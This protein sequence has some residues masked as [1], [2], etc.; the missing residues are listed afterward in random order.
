VASIKGGF[1]PPGLVVLGEDMGEVAAMETG[2]HVQA[3]CQC[4]FVFEIQMKGIA[5][6]NV[7]AGHMQRPTLQSR[8]SDQIQAITLVIAGVG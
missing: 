4:P 3:M 6:K 5:Q 2:V 8:H 1:T 7:K